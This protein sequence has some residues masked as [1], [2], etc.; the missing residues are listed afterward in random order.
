MR[1]RLECEVFLFCFVFF[2]VFNLIF[3]LICIPLYKFINL[4][5]LPTDMDWVP[6]ICQ[7]SFKCFRCSRKR[8]PYLDGSCSLFR[9]RKNKQ[10][11]IIKHQKWINAWKKNK[12][13]EEVR[14][15]T[16]RKNDLGW[17]LWK[18]DICA[19]KEIKSKVWAMQICEGSPSAKA[20]KLIHGWCVWVTLFWLQWRKRKQ[21]LRGMQGHVRKSLVVFN[22]S[23]FQNF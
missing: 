11:L 9:K 20:L 17:S 1:K 3:D 21:G 8:S 18:D 12:A 4:Y 22:L 16:C 19:E 7:H 14:D 2:E 10:V 13:G 6:T 23:N 15:L 5:I